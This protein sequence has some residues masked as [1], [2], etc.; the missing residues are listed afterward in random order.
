MAVVVGTN[1]YITRAEANTYFAE[2]LHAA[3]WDAATDE[4]KD[5]ALVTAFRMIDRQTWEGEKTV[6]SQVQE[7]PRTGLTDKDGNAV[8]SSSVP[9]EVKDGQAELA[10]SLLDDLTVQSQASTGT[11]VKEVDAKGVSVTFFN[12]SNPDEETRFPTIVQELLGPFLGND[13]FD[14]L[15]SE[16]LGSDA[17]GLFGQTEYGKTEPYG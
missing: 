13:G 10:L 6:S 11:N 12:P 1:S 3:T 8:S 4:N 16:S 2:A 17:T 15:A 14:L 9:Q 5:K 7:F